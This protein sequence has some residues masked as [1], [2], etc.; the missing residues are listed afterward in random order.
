MNFFALYARDSLPEVSDAYS[1]GERLFRI[2]QPEKAIPLLQKSLLEKK[3]ALTVYNYLGT[4]YMQT[5]DTRKALEI[6]LQGTAVP[7]TDKKSLYY[8]AG[9]AAFLLADFAKAEEYFSLSLAA[10]SS[11]ASSYLN[12]ANTQVHLGKYREAID[13]YN[14]YLVLASDSAQSAEIKRMIGAL[15]D[16]LAFQA[17]EALR[18][19]EEAER[20]KKEEQRL[21]AERERIAAEKAR[22]EAEKAAAEA[23]RRRK[24]LEEVS[25]ALQAGSSTNVSAGTEGVLDYEYEE[26]E[27]E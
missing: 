15:N 19:A 8:N 23:E 7:G 5:G 4:A 6:F 3:S 16:E 26:V 25:A 17:Q 21:Q 22:L 11:W 18:K 10:D 14:N 24:I 20:I 27:L 2:N 1:E 9:N 13:D 12:R